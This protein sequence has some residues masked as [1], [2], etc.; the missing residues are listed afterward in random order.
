MHLELGDN[1]LRLMHA[2]KPLL[3]HTPDAPC[4]FVGHGR[5]DVA[6]YRGNFDLADRLDAREPLR[7]L[8]TAENTLVFRRH[9]G[10]T[11][12]LVLQPEQGELESKFIFVDHAPGLNRIWI[13]LAAEPG[14]A[15]WGCGEQMSYFDLRGR[16]FPLWT[17]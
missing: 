10:D 5:A 7:H 14:E 9:P 15:V 8:S 16:R 2:G 12:Q 17:S 1:T 4:F 13:R 3:A 11:P 6:M